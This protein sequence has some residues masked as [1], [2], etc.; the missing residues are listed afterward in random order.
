[1]TSLYYH[2]AMD[3]LRKLTLLLALTIMSA[4]ANAQLVRLPQLNVPLPQTVDRLG[5]QLGQTLPVDL[6]VVRL[7]TVTGLLRTHRRVLE[8]DPRGEPIVRRQVL[9]FSPSP[10]ALGAAVAA[11]FTIVRSQALEG[12]D[13]TL[14]TLEA[15]AATSTAA[16]LAQLRTLDPAGSYDFNHIY[17][18]SGA[19]TAA[20]AGSGDG[21]RAG[22][23]DGGV[24]AKH[25]VFS[26]S[27][28][29]RHGCGGRE[30]PSPH[31]TGVAALMVGRHAQFNGV[32][33]GSELFAADIYCDAP[34]G[35]SA[36]RIAA[37]LSWLATEKVG[38][39]NL[40]IVGPA[41]H[42]LE[43]LV[44][45]LLR[46]G[47]LLVA[48][49][50]NDGPAA[51]PLYPAAYP[52]VVGV[53]AVGRDGQV[54]PEAARGPHVMFAAP[55]SH[56]ATAGMRAGYYQV[57]RGTSFAA[58][59]VAALLARLHARPDTALAKAAIASLAREAVKGD[60]AGLGVVGSAF[61]TDPKKISRLME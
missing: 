47:H 22:L 7:D 31:G 18:G 40:S 50:G 20:L 57:A 11:G 43:R 24:N 8:A 19:A 28:I 12:L 21:I 10:S 3:A 52:G 32:A 49:V 17:T 2:R 48:A 5:S 44:A 45:A 4:S 15:P 6:S 46:R 35:G 1:M 13:E 54:L 29:Q 36:E 60:G 25:P 16:A 34:D 55:G 59:I 51:A 38:V 41:N 26:A 14:V 53:S 9:A 33:P 39:I 58:P 42:T 61:R 23:V 27:R 30:I 37:A 56:M